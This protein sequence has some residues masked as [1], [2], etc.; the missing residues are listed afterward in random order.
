[1]TGNVLLSS[2]GRRVA[3]LRAFRASLRELSSDGMVI[4]ADASPLSA[5]FHAA[6]RAVV[7]PR[8]ISEEF[9]PA[10]LEVCRLHD[11]RLIVP[12]IDT[13]LAVLAAHRGTFADAGVIV[14]ISDPETVDV[15]ADKLRTNEW[16]VAN[17]FPTVRQA[18]PDAVLGRGDGWRYPL[19]VKPRRGSAS[20]GVTT[21]GSADE[22]DLVADADVV[23]EEVARGHEYTVDVFADRS[24]RARCA[25]PRRRLEVRSGE[26]S[27]GVTVRCPLLQQLACRVV[28][29]LPGAYGALNVQVFLDADEKQ[30]RIIEINPR[31]GGGFPLSW[32]AGAPFPRWL[33]EDGAGLSPS[34][35]ADEWRDGVVMLRYDDA[36]FVDASDVGLGQG[37]GR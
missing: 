20:I 3:L 31:F 34:A 18:R 24:G 4:A 5:A 27:K 37:S 10:L 2:A 30:P 36:I 23:V 21:V 15:G 29:A 17:G 1:M 11:V 26:V 35:V 6:D 8:C 25:V 13:E 14:A 7:V 22:L 33:L 16:L 9:V 28:E 12:T 32:E 19:V